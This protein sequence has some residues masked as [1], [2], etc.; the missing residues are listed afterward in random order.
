M[1]TNPFQISFQNKLPSSFNQD[2]SSILIDKKSALSPMDTI[3][4][5]EDNFSKL[6]TDITN[7][8]CYEEENSISEEPEIIIISERS[9]TSFYKLLQEQ[10]NN[11]N[12]VTNSL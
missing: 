8:S 3:D 10:L 2:L 7:D 5:E 4:I 6:S 11:I 12:K 1:S 9:S